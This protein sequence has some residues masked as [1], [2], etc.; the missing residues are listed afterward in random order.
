MSEHAFILYGSYQNPYLRAV[1]ISDGLVFDI[2]AGQLAQAP[3][4]EDT[5]IS[6]GAKNIV[7]N[8]WP[9]DL[10]E[11]LPNGAYDLQL[12]DAAAPDSG[13]AMI[14]GW[15]LIMPHKLVANPTEFPLDI[16]GRIRTTPA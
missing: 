4:W 2:A 1:R 11:N 3:V 9:V 8:G 5:A 7:I 15:R 10:P 6:L 13:D 16:F 14:A 12:Y